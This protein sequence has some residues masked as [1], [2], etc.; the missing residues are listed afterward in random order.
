MNS[1][2]GGYAQLHSDEQG[3]PAGAPTT[4][5]ADTETQKCPIPESTPS[6]QNRESALHTIMEQGML[7]IT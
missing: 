1:P 6:S 4:M 5:E 2:N 7:M 3:S